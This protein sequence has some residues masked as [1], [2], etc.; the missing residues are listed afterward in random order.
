MKFYYP[1][2]KVFDV[3]LVGRCVRCGTV[4]STYSNEDFCSVC[5]IREK[6]PIKENEKWKKTI[7]PKNLV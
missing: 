2:I 6:Q 7:D 3:P 1:K 5:L 4:Y